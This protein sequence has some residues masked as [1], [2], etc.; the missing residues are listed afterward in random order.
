MNLMIRPSTAEEREGA[1]AWPIWSCEPSQ[2]E[3]GYEDDERCVILEG[4]VLIEA[5]GKEW[6]LGP[7]DYAHFPKGLACRWNVRQKVVKHYHMGER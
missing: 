5:M 7:G 1:K 6:P 4:E 2:F 3:W